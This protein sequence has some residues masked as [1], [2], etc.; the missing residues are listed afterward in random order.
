MTDPN[1]YL[2]QSRPPVTTVRNMY[3]YI[4][5]YQNDIS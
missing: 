4:Y 1:P 3:M 2:T 5:I